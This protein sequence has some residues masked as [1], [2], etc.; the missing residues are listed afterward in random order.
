[1][2]FEGGA[3]LNLET[4]VRRYQHCEVNLHRLPTALREPLPVAVTALYLL[5]S[6]RDKSELTMKHLHVGEG[7]RFVKL[8][9]LGWV[10]LGLVTTWLLFNELTGTR[11]WGCI[12]SGASFIFFFNNVY[13]VDSLYTELPTA[14]LMMVVAWL[15]LLA[16]R[17]QRGPLWLAAGVGMGL[18]C[19]TKSA[20]LYIP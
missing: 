14:V 20:F 13:V 11:W 5:A 12:A 6:G 7:A 17:H 16:S 3:T 18:L 9:N 4:S 19:L 1:A 2:V 15:L 8:H 10:F